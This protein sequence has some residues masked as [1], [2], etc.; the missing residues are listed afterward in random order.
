MILPKIILPIVFLNGVD[1]T[2]STLA[3][4]RWHISN[5]YEN[6]FINLSVLVPSWENCYEKFKK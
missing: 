6:K 3:P 5:Y 4:S 1:P 2:L